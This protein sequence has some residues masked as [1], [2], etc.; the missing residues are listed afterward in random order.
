MVHRTS[1]EKIQIY[2]LGRKHNPHFYGRSATSLIA[3]LTELSRLLRPYC[4]ILKYI[5]SKILTAV[6][7]RTDQISAKKIKF[8]I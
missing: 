2:S 5:H 3:I 7:G 1:L 8:P 4:L 6:N